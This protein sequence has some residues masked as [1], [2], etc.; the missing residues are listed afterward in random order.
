[1]WNAVIDCFF[2]FQLITDIEVASDFTVTENLNFQLLALK[3]TSKLC[4]S[5]SRN[6]FN[7]GY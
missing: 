3:F 1:M 6:V 4:V 2:W 7:L 5:P